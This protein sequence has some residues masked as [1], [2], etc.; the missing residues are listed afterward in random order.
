MLRLTLRRVCWLSGIVGA[1]LLAAH[2]AQPLS[3]LTFGSP[4]YSKHV[5][6]FSALVVLMTC[7]AGRAD[8]LESTACAGSGILRGSNYH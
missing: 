5:A 7:V 4:D 1:V 2:V 3:R 6:A 8:G